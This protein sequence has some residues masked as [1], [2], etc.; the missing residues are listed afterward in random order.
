MF[1]ALTVWQHLSLIL[2]LLQYNVR[3][4]LRVLPVGSPGVLLVLGKT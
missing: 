4:M 3:K 2:R 1:F